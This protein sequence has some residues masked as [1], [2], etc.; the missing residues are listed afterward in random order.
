MVCSMHSS[1]LKEPH[2]SVLRVYS[3]R[4]YLP[5]AFCYVVPFRRVLFFF[6]LASITV[7]RFTG[8]TIVFVPTW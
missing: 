7:N 1:M 8:D 3:A 4:F 5:S 2:A 6:F